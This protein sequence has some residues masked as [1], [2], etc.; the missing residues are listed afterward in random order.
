[1][2]R[3]KILKFWLN[4]KKNQTKLENALRADDRST[5]HEIVDELNDEVMKLASCSMEVEESDDFFECTFDTGANKTAQY[6]VEVMMKSA[7]EEVSEHWIINSYR[8]PCSHRSMHMTLSIKDKEYT[9]L[10]F[11]VYYTIDDN[12]KAI[13]TKIYCP[14]FKDMEELRKN[15]ITSYMLELFVGELEIEARIASVEIVDQESDEENV[16]LLPNFYEDI[17]DIIIDKD[18]HE[19]HYPTQIYNVYKLNEELKGIGVRK[20]MVVVATSNSQL[21]EEVQN[22]EF[23]T[24]RDFKEKG[25]EY[26]Y[27]YYEHKQNGE[28]I[29]LINSQLEKQ[30]HE[31][32]YPLWIARTIGSAIGTTYCYIDLAIF[33]LDAFLEGLNKINEKLDYDLYYRPF[34][35]L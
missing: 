14:A 1:M 22:D 15:Q 31:L 16:V 8:H 28:N 13:H 29:A 18:W 6:I 11:K 2:L 24:C 32:L 26:G 20:D 19:Y 27:L 5:I 23:E 3:K 30:I 9:G 25:G 34:I 7:P 35:N 33:D 21:F 17:C 4:F 12:L 10:D